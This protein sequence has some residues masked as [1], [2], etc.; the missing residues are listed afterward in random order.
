MKR[1]LLAILAVVLLGGVAQ[2][3]VPGVRTEFGVVAGVDYPFHKF[4]MGQSAA[5]IK[6]NMGFAAGIHMGLRIVGILGVQ[7]EIIY[8]YHKLSLENSK[9]QN[10][11]TEVKCNTL[12]IPLLISLRLPVVRFNLG[13]VFTVMDNPVYLDRKSE[14]VMFGQIYP[15]VS[16]AAGVSTCLFEKLIIDARVS[17]GFKAMENFISYDAKSAGETIKT[18]TFN[19]QLKVGVLF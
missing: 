13:P 9:Q 3:G 6:A 14:K 2:G 11:S 18:T 15:M 5:Q 7:P 19:A 16:Y 10:F 17:S 4:D 8:S 12:Q 1:Y